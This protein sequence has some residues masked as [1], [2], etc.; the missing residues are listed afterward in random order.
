MDEPY[1]TTIIPTYC[2][3]TWCGLFKSIDIQSQYIQPKLNTFTIFS[4]EISSQYRPKVNRNV[5][6][7]SGNEYTILTNYVFIIMS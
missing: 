4:A 3:L 6:E 5:V 7:I 2:D 1:V